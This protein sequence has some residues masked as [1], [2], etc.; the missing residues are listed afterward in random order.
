MNAFGI[1]VVVLAK[2]ATLINAVT[3]AVFAYGKAAAAAQGRRISESTLL[4]R[5]ILGG[6]VGAVPAQRLRRH[7]TRKTPFNWLIPV[8]AGVQ[9]AVAAGILATTAKSY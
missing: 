1:D 3:F 9:P 5:I 4:G 6:G 2:F 8:V 7:K